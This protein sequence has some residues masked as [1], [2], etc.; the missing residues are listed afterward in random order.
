[1]INP[2]FYGHQIKNILN[3]Y[4]ID[5]DQIQIVFNLDKI[6]FNQKIN[7]SIKDLQVNR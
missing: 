3:F 7:F 2:N 6:S 5:F 1:M 4:K